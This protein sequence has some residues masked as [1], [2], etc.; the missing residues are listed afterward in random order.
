MQKIVVIEPTKQ[1]EIREMPELTLEIMQE[2]V[3]GYI[4]VVDC[5]KNILLVCDEEGKLKEKEFNFI[6]SSD[7]IVGTVF[8]CKGE[9]SEMIGL[10]DFQIKVVMDFLGDKRNK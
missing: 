8:F 6:T 10:T 4:Q 1:P 7:I 5:G 3:G 2:I 9:G